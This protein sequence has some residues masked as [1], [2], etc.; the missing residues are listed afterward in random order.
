MQQQWVEQ[1]EIEKDGTEISNFVAL[2]RETLN[3][4]Q[5]PIFWIVSCSYHCRRNRKLDATEFA[6][7]QKVC[8]NQQKQ[9]LE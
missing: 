1:Q 3:P 2:H 6:K 4:S 7:K 9:A 8:A 5:N